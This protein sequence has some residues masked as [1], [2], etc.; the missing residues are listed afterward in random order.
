MKSLIPFFAVLLLAC[1]SQPTEPN[2]IVTPANYSKTFQPMVFEEDNR[3]KL[4]ASI[5]P[6][7]HK[8]MT[9]YAEER[10]IPGI[11]YGIVIDDR[12][13]MDSALGVIN[14]EKGIE[15]TT[16]SAFRIASMSK[17]FTS[18]VL[19]NSVRPFKGKVWPSAQL[20]ILRA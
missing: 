16:R 18:E 7:F 4:I 19:A 9:E 6:K 15:A 13:V 5:V 2:S 10:N 20:S 8:A 1:T 3:E 17:S 12:L 14:R 11:A